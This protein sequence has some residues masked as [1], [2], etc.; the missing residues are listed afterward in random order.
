M[1]HVTKR[2]Q[3]KQLKIV[4]E[5]DLAFDYG[6][7]QDTNAGLL[8]RSTGFGDPTTTTPTCILYHIIFDRNMDAA[9]V[10]LCV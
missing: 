5:K 3:E 9:S 10:F 2:R 6:F 1:H 7:P 8:G 4:R